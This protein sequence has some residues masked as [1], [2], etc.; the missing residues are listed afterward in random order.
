VKNQKPPRTNSSKRLAFLYNFG[1]DEEKN[2]IIENLAILVNSGM[3]IIAAL[4]A[5]KTELK[6]KR[7]IR[8]IYAIQNEIEVGS[9][10]W[11]ALEGSRVFP[12]QVISLVRIGEESG[13]LSQ[14]LK[15]VAEEQQ[16]DREFRSKLRSAI[17]YPA[18]VL[19]LSFVIGT[20]IAWFVL[21]QLAKIFSQLNL[22][23][24]LITRIL[25]QLGSFL[26]QYGSIVIPLF[27]F[28]VAIAIYFVFFFRPTKYTG[29]F[30]LLHIPGIKKLLKELEL[31]RLGFILG[32][33][34]KAGV[35]VV[36]AVLSLKEASPFETYR[37]MYV[38]WGKTLEEGNSF[39][40]SF[41]L[42]P[43]SKKLIPS[44]VQQM[45]ISG[46]RSG[47]LAPTFIKIGEIYGTKTEIT[48]KNLAVVLEPI[49]LIIV[50]LGVVFI[51]LGVVMPIYSLIGGLK[52]Q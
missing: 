8:F 1:L 7:L 39:Q 3:D 37:K 25:I 4:E 38:A 45:I 10:L 22:K 27:T 42:Y 31:G 17:M 49:L 11:K 28:A 40:K 47:K 29:E 52:T 43:R 26:G 14:N 13:R 32:T 2:Y 20:G 24:P 50:W 41:A 51:A 19:V 16:K 44:P 18:F 15:I 35:P 23:L 46:E 5:I 12:A 6:S 33:L 9:S 36:G 48:T 21:P 34:L 30:L